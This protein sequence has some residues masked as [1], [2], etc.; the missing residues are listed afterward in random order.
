MPGIRRCALNWRIKVASRFGGL[1]H[2]FIERRPG[3]GH[4]ATWNGGE[5][6][7]RIGGALQIELGESTQA[8]FPE[9]AEM[10][11]RRQRT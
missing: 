8:D 4:P 10:N 5:L 9:G 6:S 11:R 7:P 3:E 2:K 1:Q